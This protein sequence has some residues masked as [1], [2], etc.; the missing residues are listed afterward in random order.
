MSIIFNLF[1]MLL[2]GANLTLGIMVFNA[3]RQAATNRQYLLLVV[4]LSVWMLMMFLAFDAS[5]ENE[6]A[7]WIRMAS[8]FGAFVPV[9]SI[10]MY[11]GISSPDSSFATLLRGAKGPAILGIVFSALSWSDLYFSSVTMP[12]PAWDGVPMPVFGPVNILLSVF[13]VVVIG[14]LMAGS[15]RR[16]KAT[17][18]KRR[19]EY[20]FVAVGLFV[21][22]I[23]GSL[24]VVILPSVLN[25]SKSVPLSFVGV[26]SMNGI[27]AYGIA[28][29][30][31]M[32]VGVLTRR[33]ISFGLQILYLG[34]VYC[35][36]YFVMH[37]VL[38]RFSEGIDHF[39]HVMAAFVTLSVSSG[40]GWVLTTFLRKIHMVAE[41]PNLQKAMQRADSALRFV[42]TTSELIN[43]IKPLLADESETDLIDFRLKQ[44]RVDDAGNGRLDAVENL[45]AYFE[46]NRIRVEPF[47][48][49]MISRISGRKRAIEA[50]KELEALD[51]VA[52]FGIWSNTELL[53]VVLLGE[54]V[55]GGAFQDAQ[56]AVLEAMIK[57][58]GSAL[59]NSMLY[60][61]V[62]SS[63]IYNEILLDNLVSGVVAI[64]SRTEIT[65]M[66]REARRILGYSDSVDVKHGF[67]ELP[68][69][70]QSVLT[71]SL[72]RG[73]RFEGKEVEISRGKNVHYD[74]SLGGAS[75]ATGIG[76]QMGALAVLHNVSRE[77]KLQSHVEKTGNLV[78]VGR[79]TKNVV[80]EFGNPLSVI[81]TFFQLLTEGRND[82]EFL[83]NYSSLA[84]DEL[85][86]MA[87]L[88]KSLLGYAKSED[89]SEHVFS[90]HSIIDAVVGLT[91]PIARNEGILVESSLLAIDDK[92]CCNPDQVKQIVMNLV[93]NG[94]QS[95]ED[96]GSLKISTKP[97][98]LAGSDDRL[99]GAA[100]EITV[101]DSGCGMSP[102]ILE[103][104]GKESFTTKA[105]GSGIGV[106]ITANIAKKL[107]GT[108]V[109]NSIQDE[110][111]QAHVV[112][113]LFNIQ[114]Q[115]KKDNVTEMY[116][117]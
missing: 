107:G 110:G 44:E 29:K 37:A 83:R 117:L 59:E 60:T 58:V 116:P 34:T 69:E 36:G 15:W 28:A 25:S 112:L 96:G 105:N 101:S 47:V 43:K 51:C 95:M 7:F 77:K 46:E 48:I 61:E 88:V 13:Y 14:W 8:T 62:Q 50:A 92:L 33:F 54:K 90:L 86:R 6:A 97:G 12:V 31:I 67:Q 78:D 16:R 70:V 27:V 76:Q 72:E 93:L 91:S 23:I 71:A 115:R 2:M 38:G 87:K 24:A 114:N 85:D 82:A 99:G 109:Y 40:N 100:I 108:L 57:K 66:N 17:D 75:F 53:G 3:N 42:T 84:G 9:C 111:T 68:T 41:P 22:L 20:L 56:L 4:N 64:N 106:S 63:K 65:V 98:M 94:I 103:K 113:P 52:A 102:E 35:G 32:N 30:R 74:I 73:R 11:L 39:S 1:L 104:L 79:M 55:K 18:E 49:S 5:N 89:A 21:L 81:Q 80:H 10:L 45:L 26:L 19:I